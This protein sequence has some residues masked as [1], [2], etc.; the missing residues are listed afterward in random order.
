MTDE[1]KQKITELRLKGMGYK[2]IA[3][4]VGDVSR[5]GV[6]Y[7][8]R[9]HGLVGGSELITLNYDLQRKRPD[10]CKQCG[11]KL[12]R[13]A[14]SG[15]KYFCCDKCRRAWWKAHPDD[16]KQTKKKAYELTCQYCHVKFIS[17]GKADRK[18]CSHD[19]Y[20]KDRFWT[21]PDTEVT[22]KEIK[23]RQEA[24]E[25]KSGDLKLRRIS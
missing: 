13:N 1:Q 2:A 12:E 24:K 25:Q 11:G 9:T 20:I 19:C 10:Y 5:E 17:Y 18:Y 22:A 7:Y 8:C 6:R 4:I 14:H 3:H 21:D 23:K 15:V 16:A